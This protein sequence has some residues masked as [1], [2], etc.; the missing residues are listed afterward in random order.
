MYN[1]AEPTSPQLV[2]QIPGLETY[3]VIAL[4]GTAIVVAKDGLY[5]FA[6]GNAGSLTQLSKLPIETN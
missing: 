2:K 5:Q 1:V 6:Y 3:D 4:D